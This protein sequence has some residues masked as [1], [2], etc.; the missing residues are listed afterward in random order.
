M[1]SSRCPLIFSAR[2]RSVSSEASSRWI[3]SSPG[4]G[5]CELAILPV[6]CVVAIGSRGTR[7]GPL[8]MTGKPV[9]S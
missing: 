9:G 5:S 6:A 4:A 7:C 1:L 8:S 2:T 3:G